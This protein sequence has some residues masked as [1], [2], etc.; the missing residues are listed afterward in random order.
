MPSDLQMR[1]LEFLVLEVCAPG[2]EP[3]NAGVIVLDRDVDRL[4][5]KVTQGGEWTGDDVVSDVV[6]GLED[7]IRSM[8][9]D[10]GAAAAMDYIESSFSGVIRA[11][12]PQHTAAAD[13]EARL[14]RLFREQV[15]SRA[16]SI[17]VVRLR[18]AAGGLSEEMPVP[19]EPIASVAPPPGLRVIPG[20][21]AAT[22]VGRSMEPLIPDGSLCL[23]RPAGGGSRDGKK[24]L[25]EKFGTF[26]ST[27]QFTVKEYRSRK[28]VLD[29]GSWEHET[30]RMIP[31]NPEFEE[32]TLAP[33]DFA[34]VAEFVAVLPPEE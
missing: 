29:D 6:G 2:S 23:F 34:V 15:D 1:P 7:E 12:D 31:L 19:G 18:A 22:V 11:T 3:R 4:W 30:I 33:D 10:H 21:F 9:R 20:M 27:S 24:L 32:W 14:R 8:A 25:I 5:V 17:P 28:R 13:P 26:D 16:A